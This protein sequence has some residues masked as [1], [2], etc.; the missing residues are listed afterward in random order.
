MQTFFCLLLF[1]EL[2]NDRRRG[3]HDKSL[4]VQATIVSLREAL[5]AELNFLF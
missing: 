5:V 4:K 1:G 3:E 2:D